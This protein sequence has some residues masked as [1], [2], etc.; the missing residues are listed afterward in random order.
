MVLS[1]PAFIF[2]F[3]PIFLAVY[4]ATPSRFRNG[5]ILVASLLFYFT[6]TGILSG[7]LFGSI[8]CNYWIALYC[9][10][11][12][13]LTR[14]LVLTLGIFANLAPLI[15]YKYW[16]FLIH[17]LNDTAAL[18]GSSINFEV[19]QIL[20]PIGI[21]FFT[22]HAI[23]YLVDVYDYKV[24]PAT[25]F[26]DF[27]MYMAFFPKLIVGPI[28]RYSEIVD[29]IRDRKVRLDQ[30]CAGLFTFV[31]GLSKKVVLADSV[32]KVADSIFALPQ[33]N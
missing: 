3:L 1:S 4:F 18:F 32:G 13:A 21:S 8:I 19:S 23:S 14:K 25:S 6:D 7:I 24:K 28:V 15:Y 16:M 20:F 11:S 29:D 9:Y 30:I 12:S 2:G 26:V 17:S 10:K 27:G 22:F 33:V 5:L 31:I